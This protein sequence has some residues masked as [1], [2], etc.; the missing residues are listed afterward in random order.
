MEKILIF[1]DGR[2]QFFYRVYE[3]SVISRRISYFFND[4]A[5]LTLKAAESHIFLTILRL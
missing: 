5:T 3:L 1:L 4:S 2:R